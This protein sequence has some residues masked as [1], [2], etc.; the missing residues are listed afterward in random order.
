MCNGRFGLV[1][2]GRTTKGVIEDSMLSAETLAKTGREMREL[3]RHQRENAQSPFVFVSER[4][5]PLSA[6]GSVQGLF[7]RLI[8]VARV[9]FE[10]KS[11]PVR[12]VGN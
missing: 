2:H 7:P 4:G 1:R 8:Y 3:R 12:A 9:C 6:P 5:A 10:I 11:R